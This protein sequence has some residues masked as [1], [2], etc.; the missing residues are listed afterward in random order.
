MNL[1][2]GKAAKEYELCFQ[3][4]NKQFKEQSKFH[5]NNKRQFILNICMVF[6][7]LS[8]IYLFAHTIGFI[9]MLE[10]SLALCGGLYVLMLFGSIIL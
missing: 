7:F 1:F 6:F 3:S 4:T 2:G 8:F 9:K 10:N 5:G